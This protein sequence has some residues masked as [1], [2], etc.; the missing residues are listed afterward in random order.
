MAKRLS[1]SRVCWAAAVRLA[2]VRSVQD[3][4]YGTTLSGA[5]SLTLRPSRRVTQQLFVEP[6]G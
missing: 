4:G 6:A 3:D 2:S 1:A 5:I